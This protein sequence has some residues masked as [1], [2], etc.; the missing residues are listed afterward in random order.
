MTSVKLKNPNEA[1]QLLHNRNCLDREG[2]NVCFEENENVLLNRYEF[3][4]ELNGDSL[5]IIFSN[6]WSDWTKPYLTI[7][8]SEYDGCIEVELIQLELGLGLKINDEVVHDYTTIDI[9]HLL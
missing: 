5:K 9:Y 2:I 6:D 7:S 1:L 8:L 3:N 4:Q